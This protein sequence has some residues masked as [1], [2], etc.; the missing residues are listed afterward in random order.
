MLKT[1][2]EDPDM[3]VL[4]GRFG[5]YICYKKA[6][7][8]IPKGTDAASLTLEQCKAIVADE[9]NAPKKRT[10]RAKK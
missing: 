8:K 7:Y 10:S 9:A 1:F 3:Q 6:N 2:D 4:N 5:V